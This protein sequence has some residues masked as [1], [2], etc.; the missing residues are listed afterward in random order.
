MDGMAVQGGAASGGSDVDD[1]GQPQGGRHDVGDGGH[2]SRGVAGAGAVCDFAMWCT[3]FSIDQWPRT[4]AASWPASAW[5]A[6]R[7][8]M[9]LDD[10]LAIALAVQPADVSDDAEGSAGQSMKHQSHQ[11]ISPNRRCDGA[12]PGVR[13]HQ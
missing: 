13:R 5:S 2:H 8:V 1:F 7:L 3:E 6:R 12:L 4:R 10:F 9:P 11:H